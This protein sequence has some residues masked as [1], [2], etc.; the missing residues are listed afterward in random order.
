MDSRE[1]EL[2]QLAAEEMVR[3]AVGLITTMAL[4]F[5]IGYVLTHRYMAEQLAARARAW[6]AHRRDPDRAETARAVAELQRAVSRYE[7]E[8]AAR[9]GPSRRP[10]LYER[11]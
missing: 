9:P 5:G 2:Q 10:G 1:R 3:Q 4:A 6:Y 7:H 11:P 8:Q